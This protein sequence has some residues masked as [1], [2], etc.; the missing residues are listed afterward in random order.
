MLQDRADLEI[1]EVEHCARQVL[2]ADDPLVRDEPSQHRG[3]AHAAG[4]VQVQNPLLIRRV[5][6]LPNRF[7]YGSRVVTRGLIELREEEIAG[8]RPAADLVEECQRLLVE[9]YLNGHYE[10]EQT[11]A[12]C[13]V[14]GP[15]SLIER[16]GEYPTRFG[17]IGQ[18][19]DL[20]TIKL[21][22]RIVGIESS[23]QR[24]DPA[25]AFD[26]VCVP[27]REIVCARVA[28]DRMPAGVADDR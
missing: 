23:G 25:R 9:K 20:D 24:V 27:L 3:L 13:D 15:I 10:L 16:S 14:V 21:L 26:A 11:A 28:R 7:L 8:L 2:W 19:Q 12:A 1:V 18:K 22:D 17:L 4:G 5:C 6:E